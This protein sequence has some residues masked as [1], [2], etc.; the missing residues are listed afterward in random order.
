VATTL[1]LIDDTPAPRMAS[2]RALLAMTRPTQIGLIL[3]IFMNGALLALWRGVGMAGDG[4]AICAAAALLILA[5]ASVHLA[6]EAVDR[7]TDRLTRR[8]P[9][10]GGSGALGASGLSPS[11]PL[12]AA[13]VLASTCVAL[14][15]LVLMV[16]GLSLAAALILLMGLAG[17]LAYSLPPL[18]IS[19][20]GLGEP[21]NAVLG[22]WL[23]P[24]FG[25][26]TVAATV[27]AL[28]AVAF[29]PFLA[30]TFASVLATAWPDRLADAATG[31]AT[32]QVRLAPPRL[33]RMA[34]ASLIVFVVGTALSAATDA[35]PLAMSGLLVSPLLV[36]GL[37]R[38]TR[39]ESPLANVAA[40]V[41]WS[42]ITL[43][44]LL[45]SLGGEA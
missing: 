9:F 5:A 15:L 18:A 34:L 19:R 44:S 3:I 39:L 29:L 7:D 32:L 43:V 1:P 36:V 31:K 20:R 22:A 41:G 35:M 2:P 6:N 25:V 37:R 40:M 10:S 17:G 28:D 14:T 21:F 45:V 38:Y 13:L 26:A 16:G 23:L 33:R 27:T 42:A 11:V 8:T 12:A 4:L 30:V 24:L